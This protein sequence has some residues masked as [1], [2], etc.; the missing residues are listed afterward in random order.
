M[1][2]YVK[3]NGKYYGAESFDNYVEL[4]AIS[5][6]QSVLMLNTNLYNSEINAGRV[7][8]LQFNS[9]LLDMADDSADSCELP[10]VGDGFTF[11]GDEFKVV[12]VG[13]GV[14]I[15]VVGDSTVV[16][17]MTYE[18]YYTMVHSEQFQQKK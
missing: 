14:I 4:T 18:Q 5:E 1:K 12:A 16:E 2:V 11:S 3:Y 7:K 13:E 8:V 6:D 10:K 17:V 15:T 9:R